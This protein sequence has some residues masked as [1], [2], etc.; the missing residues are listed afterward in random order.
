MKIHQIFALVDVSFDSV[1]NAATRNGSNSTH[2]AEVAEQLALHNGLNYVPRERSSN[3]RVFEH[4]ADSKVLIDHLIQLQDRKAKGSVEESSDTTFYVK[5][6]DEPASKDAKV[7][8]VI[9][10]EIKLAE[11]YQQ[12]IM[13]E[14]KIKGDNIILQVNKPFIQLTMKANGKADLYFHAYF[15]EKYLKS[16]NDAQKKN[17]GPKVAKKLNDSAD[18]ELASEVSMPTSSLGG[19]GID[20]F[21]D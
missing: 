8:E 16:L 19:K 13:D 20:I 18:N 6:I 4:A 12:K 17:G 21:S 10:N 2:L 14:L 11:K 5:I 7:D 15:W 9:A 3:G 1:L